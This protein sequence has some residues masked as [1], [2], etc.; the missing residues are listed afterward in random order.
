MPIARR[1]RPT[2]RCLTDDLG[3]EIPGLEVDLGVLDH[4]LLAELRRV[5][6]TSPD[7][8]KRILSIDHPLVYRIRV[9]SGR[10]VTWFEETKQVVWL[11]AA[12]RR[13]Q[14]SDDDAYRHFARLHASAQL[15]PDDDDD[16]RDRAEAAIRL[17]RGVTADLLDLVNV[18]LTDEGNENHR[19]LGD[20]LP[21]RILVLHSDD[22]EEIWCALSV[23]GTDGSFVPEPIRDLLFAALEQ[24]VAPA[25]FEAR[26]D[27]P[28]GDA[29]WFEVV[30]LA[31]R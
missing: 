2:L 28:D 14:D 3:I 7:G 20:W 29:E 23:R 22:V 16:M 25:L 17:Q 10:G 12:R 9:S 30:R 21:C 18:A 8:Q 6:P 4:P 13:E 26:N 24:H 31:M 27:W 19:D 1:S 15:L 5:T 11:C